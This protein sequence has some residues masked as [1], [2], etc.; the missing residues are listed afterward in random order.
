MEE[1]L[2]VRPKIALGT[3]LFHPRSRLTTPLTGLGGRDVLHQ[4]AL[5]SPPAPRAPRRPQPEALV[6]GQAM[7]GPPPHADVPHQHLKP[8]LPAFTGKPGDALD[9]KAF[10]IQFERI[11]HRQD[12]DE[13]VKLDRLIECH[14]GQ[15]AHFFSRLPP[16]HREQYRAICDRLLL[17]CSF[18]PLVRTSI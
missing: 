15:A 13:E 17:G 8:K 5:H 16:A 6:P 9:W 11:A 12:W 7:R 1:N 2:D 4:E 10:I 18:A 3:L 14:Q